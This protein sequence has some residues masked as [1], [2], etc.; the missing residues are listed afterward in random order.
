[1]DLSLTSILL[2]IGIPII[3]MRSSPS[4]EN[5]VSTN[6]NISTIVANNIQ[7]AALITFLFSDFVDIRNNDNTATE[8]GAMLPSG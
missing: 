5:L 2:K 7:I 3:A 6:D 4:A 1:M 8:Y